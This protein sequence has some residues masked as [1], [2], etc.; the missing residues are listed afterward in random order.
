MF[1]SVRVG[2]LLLFILLNT[3]PIS[4]DSVNTRERTTTKLAEGVYMIRHPD[5]PD[6][7]PQ[8]NTTVIIGERDV[9]VIDS[10]YLPSDARKDIAQIHEWTDK[11][12]RYLLNTH[13]HNDHIQGNKVYWETFPSITIIGHTE[14]RKQM[15]GYVPNYM[16]GRFP[17]RVAA[18]KQIL[19][20]GKEE[21]GTPISEARRE[22]VKANLA[23]LEPIDT[24]FRNTVIQPPNLTFDQ[25][26]DIDLGNR[27]AQIRFL[28]RGNTAGDV[29]VYLPKE[30]ILIA[31]DLLDH[32]V[33]YL[34]GGFPSELVRTL[35]RMS[36][37]DAQTIIPGHGEV[38]GGDYARA[39]LNQV[40]DFI[41]TIT[42]LV[43]KET[44]RLGNG[45]RNLEAV[46]EA[47]LK[48]IDVAAWRKKFGGDD[49]DNGDF[50]EGFSLAGVITAAYREAWGN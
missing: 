48:S 14:T 26:L 20:T 24:E 18:L 37:I 46:R 6:D 42:E 25:E 40:I 41:Q 12:V 36:E 9:M 47:V 17:K 11:P 43:R 3:I 30:K 22:E 15:E 7:F 10:C 2:T 45:A 5:A 31:G 32:P 34:G 29:V 21:D 44:Y 1:L 23:K 38:L 16:H 27:E 50:F 33:P 19:E 28:G 8:G 13:W 4:A 39:Y 49:K 35:K